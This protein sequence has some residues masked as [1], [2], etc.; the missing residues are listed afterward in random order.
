MAEKVTV[1]GAGTMGH[2]IAQLYAQAGY[3]VFLYDIKAEFLSNAEAASVTKDV[4]LTASSEKYRKKTSSSEKRY[5]WF[6][7]QSLASSTSP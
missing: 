1:L 2:G 5:P 7:C 6:H 3:D 4:S